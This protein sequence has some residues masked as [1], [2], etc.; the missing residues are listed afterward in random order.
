MYSGTFA[1]GKHCEVSRDSVARER[2]WN[3]PVARQQWSNWEAVFSTQSV[4]VA[5]WCN[6]RT[7]GRGVFYAVHAK[8]TFAVDCELVRQI[9]C[10][11]GVEYLHRSPAS[12]RRRHKG[13]SQIWVRKIRSRVT[14]DSDPK[15]TALAKTSNCKRQTRPL[16]RDSA[17]HR[18]TRNCLTVIKIWS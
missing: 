12:R 14:R 3:T 15:M 2:L 9:P 17:P 7:V 4:P 8:A 6:N 5:T 18:Q 13:K 11:G 1:Q 10:G 16:V